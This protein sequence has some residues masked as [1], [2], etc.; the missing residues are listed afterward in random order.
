MKTQVF[1]NRMCRLLPSWHFR[2]AHE[3]CQQPPRTLGWGVRTPQ[4]N[5]YSERR[6]FRMS[7]ACEGLSAL[8]FRITASASEPQ[9]C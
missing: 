8:K 1:I 4:P 9:F 2:L 7:C 6:K 3:A 5:V